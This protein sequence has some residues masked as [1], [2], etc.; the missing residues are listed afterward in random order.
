MSSGERE[1][2]S[3]FPGDGGGVRGEPSELLGH[4][5]LVPPV[6]PVQ[7]RVEAVHLLHPHCGLEHVYDRPR[8]LEANG[9]PEP[10][11]MKDPNNINKNKVRACK[12]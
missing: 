11:G 3:A 6:S 2:E 1:R 9:P 7:V 8:G 12:I 5:Q 4:L 10:N